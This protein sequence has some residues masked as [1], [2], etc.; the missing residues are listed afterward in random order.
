M[1]KIELYLG[2]L[3]LI[4]VLFVM[5]ISFRIA[6]SIYH[7][8]RR[9][10]L[11]TRAIVKEKWPAMMDAYDAWKLHSY[12]VFSPF[13]YRLR[14]YYLPAEDLRSRKLAIIAHGYT[15]THHGAIKYAHMMHRLGYSVVFY[16]ER[17][18]GDSGGAN[19]TLGY[20]ESRDL[21]AII[22]DVTQRFGEG[23]EIGLVGE[24]MGAVAAILSAS[25]RQTIRFVIA[26]CPFADLEVLVTQLVKRDYHLPKWPFVSMARILFDGITG[27]KMRDVSPI[28]A[29]RTLTMPILFCH[30]KNDQFTLPD[31]SE[32]L[33]LACRSPK[34]LYLAGNDA[35]HADSFRNN[36]KEYFAT[37]ESFIKE[38]VDERRG[39]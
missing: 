31:H 17:F 3:V 14:C 37:V 7:P 25:R 39:Y 15:F 4:A 16:D 19:T 32:A 9:S 20:Y 12:E 18:H 33:Y 13:D 27:A 11:E 28:I 30:G 36:P 8:K 38:L 26:D 22:D 23:L 5:V 21:E 1:P 6:L 10:L 2:F 24:S 34:R 29:V 35:G